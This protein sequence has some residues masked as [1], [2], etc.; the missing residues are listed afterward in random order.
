MARATARF[1]ASESMRIAAKLPVKWAGAGRSP[2]RITSG[3][4][5]GFAQNTRSCHSMAPETPRRS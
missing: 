4:C 5:G 1:S 2:G 3:A